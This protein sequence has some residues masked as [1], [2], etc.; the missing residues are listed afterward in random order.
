MDARLALIERAWRAGQVTKDYFEPPY[1]PQMNVGRLM[2]RRKVTAC[3]HTSIALAYLATGALL[4]PRR[5]GIGRVGHHALSLRLA[6]WTRRALAA[7][8]RTSY[9]Y[10][11]GVATEPALRGAPFGAT[12]LLAFVNSG[13]SAHGMEIVTPG[14]WRRAYQSHILNQE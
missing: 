1:T 14:I 13:R 5:R 3:A 10:D 7:T 11:A 12:A 6:N 4:L 9:F 8:G 2:M